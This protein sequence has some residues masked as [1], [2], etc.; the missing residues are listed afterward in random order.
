MPFGR[1]RDGHLD[2]HFL[3]AEA[4]CRMNTD[5]LGP[6]SQEARL[7][8]CISGMACVIVP[9]ESEGAWAEHG[10]RWGHISCQERAGVTSAALSSFWVLR[11][12]K[13]RLDGTGRFCSY[14]HGF[15][16]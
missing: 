4:A 16:E 14:P 2:G 7:T 1:L 3:Q 13:R 8:Q 10:V 6:S 12:R 5:E 9:K 11:G 15:H